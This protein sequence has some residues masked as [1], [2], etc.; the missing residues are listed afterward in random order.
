[1]N[2]RTLCAL[3]GA[4]LVAG[5]LPA[6]AD[7]GLWTFDQPPL[8]RLDERHRFQPTPQ[9]LDRLRLAAVDFRGASA[10]FVSAAGLVLTNH[11]VGSSCLQKLSSAQRDL[12]KNGY[13]A[14]RR[15]DELRCPDTELKVLHSIS[16]ISANILAAGAAAKTDEDAN[17]RRKEAIA[18]SEKRCEA[19]TR[20]RCSVVTLY[21]GAM[22]HLY[23]YHAWTDVRLVFAPE[24]EV[25]FFGG[26]PD[27]F[28]FPRFDL[29][30]ALFR[31]YEQGRPVSPRSYLKLA[32]RGVK[33]DELVFAAGHPHSTDRLF[34]VA[35]LDT[36][37][38]VDYPLHLASAKRQQRLLHGFGQQSPEATRRAAHV[39]FGTENWLK[40]MLGEFKT[41]RDP[42]FQQAKRSEEAKFRELATA[43]GNS[44][45]PWAVLAAASAKHRA[46]AKEFWA[47]AYG[48]RTLL[49]AA[50]DIVEIAHESALPEGERLS[51]YRSAELPKLKRRLEADYPIYKDLEITRQAD[52]WQEARDLLG[53]AHPFVKTVLAG[54]TP[55]EAA[56]ERISTSR[57][58]RA[59]ERRRLLAGGLAAI[60]ASQDPLIELARAIYPLRRTLA[61]YQEVEIETPSKKASQALGRLRFEVFGRELPP[62]A[63]SSLRLSYGVV[64]GYESEGTLVPWKTNF[65]G[66]F[67]RHDAFD[68]KPPFALPANWLGARGKLKPE[69]PFN[70]ASTI[71]IIGG[72]S[73][74]PV[75]NREGEWV[76]VIF[77]GNLEGLG[78]R[79]GYTET[80]ARS[81]AV[82][83]RAILE[84]LE[85]VYGAKALAAEIRGE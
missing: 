9:W 61:K 4:L 58:D 47:V 38:E 40:A 59:E 73:G 44:D 16:D 29:D 57:I 28:V 17:R 75:V 49:Q 25:A 13:L 65:G 3:G 26:D 15:E 34:T 36:Q 53:D 46:K 11:H 60:K 23:R 71:D 8:A 45:D 64:K 69:T 1:M 5:T 42:V 72:N 50:G 18:E 81:L 39:L 19:Q 77:D 56:S 70:F 66:L 24:M 67:A 83:S 43:K 30:I 35:E 55:R 32:R 52:Y 62:D 27:N 12:M 84:A 6:L 76:G 2:T 85:V 51:A 31:I 74:S 37:R 33:E 80:A 14:P 7:E 41:L 63:T 54:K 48:Y 22:Y 20:L 68:G 82:D 21:H 78:N 79:F 10:S